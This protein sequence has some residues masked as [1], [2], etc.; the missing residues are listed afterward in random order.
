V[1]GQVDPCMLHSSVRSRT[2]PSFDTQA[3]V[4]VGNWPPGMEKGDGDS[5]AQVSRTKVLYKIKLGIDI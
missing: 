5:T 1:R 2:E 4:E 3:E